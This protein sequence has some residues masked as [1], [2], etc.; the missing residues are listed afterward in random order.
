MTHFCNVQ[1]QVQKK[2]SIQLVAEAVVIKVDP[3]EE[4]LSIILE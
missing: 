2:F 1:V 4:Y 3:Q